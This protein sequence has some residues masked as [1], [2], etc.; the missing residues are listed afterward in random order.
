VLH[1]AETF[2]AIRWDRWFAGSPEIPVLEQSKWHDRIPFFARRGQDG[3]LI[4]DGDLENVAAAEVAYA[5]GMG[6]DYFIFG[7]YPDTGSWGR[8]KKS[9]YELD[10][11]LISYLQ[12]PDRLGVKFAI[13]L[14]QLFP[15]EDIED[16]TETII[17]LGSHPDYMRTNSGTLPLFLFAQDGLDF[18]KYFGSDDNAR[19][20]FARLRQAVETKLGAKLTIIL[21]NSNYKQAEEAR[22]RYGLDML[23]TY[24]NYSPGEGQ[25]S[26][27][28][29]VKHNAAVWASAIH[30]HLLYL[31][32]VT[33]G[34]DSRPRGDYAV[35]QGQPPIKRSWCTPPTEPELIRLFDSAKKAASSIPL[36]APFRSVIIYAWNEFTEGGWLLPTWDNSAT[37]DVIRRAIN[38]NKTM[39]D[40]RL[41]FPS[42]IEFGNCPIRSTDRPLE[43]VE[44]C[45]QAVNDRAPAWPCPPG[46]HL[47]QDFIR[48]PSGFEAKVSNGAWRVRIC[49][50]N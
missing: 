42:S 25:Q 50:T 23:S 22:V 37:S 2:G 28:S 48:A 49:K 15:L 7:F 12:L 21:L 47:G 45:M 35:A 17:N 38:A 10:R 16:V 30:E 3:H 34:W 27:E 31:P 20:L 44:S 18:S 4:L 19:N 39:S 41:Q 9:A 13:S 46:T 36:T 5:R 40:I 33:I 32:N 8:S 43:S 26:F 24:T 29:C 11:A 14:N 1:D 6:I